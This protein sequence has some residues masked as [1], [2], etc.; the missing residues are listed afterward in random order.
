MARADLLIDIVRAGAEGNQELFRRAL[1]ALITEE[2]S[3]QHH[4]LADRLAAHLQLNGHSKPTA[5]ITPVSLNGASRLLLELRPQRR[6]EDLLLPATVLQACSELIEE[7]HRADLLRAHNLEPRHRLLL[8]GPPGNGNTSLAAAALRLLQPVQEGAESP[9]NRGL[10]RFDPAGGTDPLEP[11]LPV[12]APAPC[13]H[14][15]A[16]PIHQPAARSLRLRQN[17]HQHLPLGRASVSTA[18]V[19]PRPSVALPLA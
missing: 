15:P 8:V 3:K 11:S 13:P 1:E 19:S 6:L 17:Y 4:V 12:S 18:S 2:R 9:G 10:K 16:P 14:R 5:P 7:H